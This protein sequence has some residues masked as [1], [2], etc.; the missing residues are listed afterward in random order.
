[1]VREH[2][3]H[4]R[5]RKGRQ[6]AR[7]V[8]QL[9]AK[10]HLGRRAR[11]TARAA[12]S[13][14][15][16]HHAGNLA[17]WAPRLQLLWKMT[18]WW[19]TQCNSNTPSQEEYCRKCGNHWTMVWKPS[20]KKEKKE[21]RDKRSQSRSAQKK[22]SQ[23]SKEAPPRLVATDGQ[24]PSQP[25]QPAV[26]QSLLD[27]KVFPDSVPWIPSTPVSRH[28]TYRQDH[29][30]EPDRL[31]VPPAPELPAPPD[32]PKVN[33]DGLT[34]QEVQMMKHIRGLQA[35]GCELPSPMLSQLQMLEAK[36]KD[37]AAQKVLSHKHLNQAH[38]YNHMVQ[39][40][41]KRIQKLDAEWVNF[42]TS[43]KTQLANHV[44]TYQA[45]R[46]D[47][48]S[49]HNTKLQLLSEARQEL[50]LASQTLVEQP[51]VEEHVPADAEVA[52]TLQQM[53][54]MQEAMDSAVPVTEVPML[55]T[56]FPEEDGEEEDVE[57]LEEASQPSRPAKGTALLA[58]RVAGS[59]TKVAHASKPR[60][61][62]RPAP[63]MSA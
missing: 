21:S 62:Q 61:Q 42:T 6:T 5:L 13:V 38:K 28:S 7:T 58:F 34:E 48:L 27:W 3:W 31:P 15:L 47:M 54:Q 43:V 50:A 25:S 18:S 53:H 56:E 33:A 30:M 63:K 35:L 1:M 39:Q 32:P 11:K 45:C 4:R 2:S 60:R 26:P 57:L 9:L 19:C 49:N 16:Q 23:P 36:T 44:Q 52:E 22:G 55:S 17:D 46:A 8:L 10:R 37:N 24:Y 14:V 40:S 41:A 12:L 51:V 29:G 20:K 59:P